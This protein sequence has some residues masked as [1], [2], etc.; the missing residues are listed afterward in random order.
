MIAVVDY[1]VG[2][3]H[4]VTKALQKVGAQARVTDDWR[5]VE[6]AKGVVFPGVGAFK[7]SMDALNRA[8]LAKAVLSA[9]Q[10]GKPFLGICVG[11]QM[12]FEE[13]EE[14]GVSKGLGVIP[15]R[16][17]K[18]QEGQKV[19]HL[20]WNSLHFTKPGNPLL[21]GVPEGSYVYFVHSFYGRPTDPSWTSAT[22]DYGVEFTAFAWKN[23]VF[24]T[25][26]HPEKSQAVGLKMLENFSRLVG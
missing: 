8:D 18:F 1:G 4:S 12:L 11:L 19:P 7:D 14:F 9:I 13:S 20:G 6:K 2:N 16:V 21:E 3:L 26:F 5:E 24:A 15:G 23:N 17:V 10:S 25:Q 22:S